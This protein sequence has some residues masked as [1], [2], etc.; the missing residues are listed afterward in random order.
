V[1]HPLPESGGTK[2]R[3]KPAARSQQ[4][5]GAFGYQFFRERLTVRTGSTVTR[6][7]APKPLK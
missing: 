3:R 5:L 1:P 4:F 6:G 2:L 7:G